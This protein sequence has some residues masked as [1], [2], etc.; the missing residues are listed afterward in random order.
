[1]QVD[2]NSTVGLLWYYI[3]L[4]SQTLGDLCCYSSNLSYSKKL[5]NSIPLINFNFVHANPGERILEPIDEDDIRK[6]QSINRQKDLSV[7]KYQK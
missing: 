3:H 5:R 7:V 2:C 4:C 1:L 6:R